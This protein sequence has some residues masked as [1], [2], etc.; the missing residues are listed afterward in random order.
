M[1][2]MVCWSVKWTVLCAFRFG[3]LNGNLTIGER[4]YHAVSLKLIMIVKACIRFEGWNAIRSNLN[5]YCYTSLLVS[6]PLTIS[7]LMGTVVP[8]SPFD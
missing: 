6:A 1:A 3:Y 5:C 8:D 2:K 7:D 4:V